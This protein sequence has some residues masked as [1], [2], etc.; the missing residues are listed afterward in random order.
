MSRSRS[1]VLTLLAMTAFAGNSLLCRMALASTS[2]DPASFTSI[3]IISGAVCLWLIVMT[4]GAT[5]GGRGSW[6]SA[7]VLFSYAAGFS[8][9]YVSLPA[10]TGALL[11]FGAVQ[12]TMIGHGMR[13]GEAFGK[14]ETAGLVIA[15]AGLIGLL[16]P[17]ITAPS[18]GGS[19]LM[20]A[21]GVAWGIYSLRGRRAGDPTQVTSGNFLRAVPFAAALGVAALPWISLDAQGV[22]YAL[23]SGVLTSGIGYSIW[24]TALKG[25]TTTEAAIVQLSVPVIAAAGGILFLGERL[26][27]RLVMVSAAILGGIA[28]VILGKRQAA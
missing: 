18:P 27:L 21:A 17:G 14:R 24:Y 23:A 7:L 16:S 11:L 5:D 6:L 28:L 10:G 26:T 4:R 19:A 12:V 9:A 13:K 1:L 20:L 15:S 8:F 2:T 25:L 22:G 3:R